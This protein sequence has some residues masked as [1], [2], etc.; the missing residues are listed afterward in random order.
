MAGN[1]RLF[2][3]SN[4]FSL[5][6]LIVTK[7]VNQ[8]TSMAGPYGSASTNNEGFRRGKKQLQSKDF[9]IKTNQNPSITLV[10]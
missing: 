5:T 1:R 7:S 3:I 9:H 4:T 10:A 2:Q 6:T 8:P